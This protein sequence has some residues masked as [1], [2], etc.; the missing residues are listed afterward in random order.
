VAGDRPSHTYGPAG[1][2]N[3]VPDGVPYFYGFACGNQVF[4]N[5]GGNDQPLPG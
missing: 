3:V 2:T 5:V 4:P 1:C